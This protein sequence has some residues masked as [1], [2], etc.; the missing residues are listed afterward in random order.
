MISFVLLTIAQ[1]LAFAPSNNAGDQIFVGEEPTR[2]L[3]YHSQRQ[4]EIRSHSEGWRSFIEGEGQGW[5]AR[6]DEHTMTPHRMWGAGIDIGPTATQSEVIEGLRR[7]FGRNSALF[8]VNNSDMPL[9]SSGYV[10][11]TDTWL[12]QFGRLVDGVEVWRGGI[13][14]RIQG[15]R[16]V[17]LGADTHPQASH[18]STTPEVQ[19]QQAEN[20]AVNLG[21]A[22]NAVHEA[23][24]STLVLIPVNGIAGLTYRLVW[25]VT[26]ETESPRGQWVTNIDAFTGE[27]F[28]YSNNIRFWQG[29]ISGTH[30]TRTI[31]G[32]ITTSPLPYV[33][34]VDDDSRTST[35]ENGNFSLD[36][37]AELLY[38]GFQGEW[39]TVRN[40]DGENARWAFSSEDHQWVASESTFTMA[41][42]DSYIFLHHVRE[43]GEEFAP[44]VRMNTDHLRSTVNIDSS[45]NAYY[46]GNVNFYQSGDG[47]NNTGRIADVNYHEWGHGFHYY[48]LLAGSWDAA[49]G[50]GIGDVV[51][52]LLTGDNILAPGF[53]TNG[54]GIR[55][56]SPN[57]VYP[58][59]ITGE[60]HGDGLIFAGAVWDLWGIL[61]D[62]M[63]ADTAHSLVSSLFVQAIKSGPTVPDTYDEFIAAD[64]DDNDLSNGTPN[65]CEILEAFQ[66]HGLGPMGSE[67]L[68]SVVHEPIDNQPSGL[69]D[70]PVI[71]EIVNLAPACVELT[72]IEG[73]VIYSID[74]GDSWESSPLTEDEDGFVTGFIPDMPNGTLVQY[75][76]EASTTEG[77]LFQVPDG[78]EYNPHSFYVGE[79]E[80]ILCEDFED[81]DGDYTHELVQGSND[82][83]AD[84]WQLGTP[85]GLS[86][87]P[88]WSASGTHSWG[89][90]LG[91][92]NFN[93]A[94]QDDKHNRLNSP[95]IEIGDETGQ[96]ILQFRRWL[97]VEDGYYDSASV[98]V[99][100]EPMWS[101]HGSNRDVGDEHHI[102]LTWA[103][104]T[105]DIEDIDGD[106]EINLSWDLQSDQGLAMGGWNIDDVCVY[107]LVIPEVPEEENDY[108]TGIDDGDFGG[109]DLV[110]GGSCGC[111]SSNPKGLPSSLLLMF[112]ALIRFRRKERQC[113]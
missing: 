40:D 38:T 53:M 95:P 23:L 57:R 49:A 58:D 65:Q 24:E 34:V 113:S 21:P 15:G 85:A 89:N 59:D 1:T 28:G 100:G 39:I 86:G 105:M 68:S 91:W 73:E 94:Y 64:D 98:L 32:E 63:D 71:G 5:M 82:E 48:S 35:D 104:H 70:I 7:F 81:G 107:R 20:L 27:L 83:G 67:S 22:A 16:L 74:G 93:G 92:D 75:F 102:D 37:D 3:T 46:D 31:N 54:A 12:V 45:C 87:D 56:L 10:E 62:K 25:Q 76:L 96:L 79:L 66:P 60:P 72:N 18:S 50:E 61:D 30:D 108:D 106:G 110:A 84:D 19:Q 14:A 8:G 51:S 4:H 6:F 97:T 109:V 11:R 9:V 41:E 42:L 78:G 77:D 29:N 47:C 26:S 99:D 43:W 17:L 13:T 69:G 55:D 36:T 103:L 90:D 33:Y 52:T 2:I 101:N 112:A 111:S 88:S 80:V 44:E